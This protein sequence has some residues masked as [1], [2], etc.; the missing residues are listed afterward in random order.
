MH[1]CKTGKKIR[2]IANEPIYWSKSDTV[3]CAYSKELWVQT[4][5]YWLE[6]A[7]IWC[8]WLRTAKILTRVAFQTCHELVICYSK[9]FAKRGPCRVG[10][11]TKKTLLKRTK[12]K[13]MSSFANKTARFEKICNT[14]YLLTGKPKGMYLCTVMKIH[15]VKCVQLSRMCLVFIKWSV[16]YWSTVDTLFNVIYV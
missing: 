16:T 6:C 7:R 8:R 11:N 10:P 1:I 2:K 4:G 5:V 14:L 9:P 12:P 13:W 15:N 3:C